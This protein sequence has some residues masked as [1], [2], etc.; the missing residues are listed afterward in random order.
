MS[1]GIEAKP[2]LLFFEDDYS[3]V[4]PHFWQGHVEYVRKVLRTHF[5]LQ[6]ADTDREY[7]RA[8]DEAEPDLI[9]FDGGVLHF[10]GRK[11]RELTN[12]GSDNSVPLVG[13]LRTDA[14]SPETIEAID[15]LEGYGVEAFFSIDTGMGVCVGDLGGRLFY[16]P[17]S[18]DETLFRDYGM[19]KL[20]P[21]SMT[22]YGFITDGTYPW[23]QCVFN[24]IAEN[25]PCFVSNRPNRKS[26]ILLHG[27]SYARVLNQSYVSLGCGC[28]RRIL[29]RK[30][31]EIPAC[32][33]LLG[34]EET[35]TAKAAGFVDGENCLFLDAMTA[36]D[37]LE[38]TFSDLERLYGM[39][40]SGREMV[41]RH[42]SMAAR[43]QLRD[44]LSLRKSGLRMSQTDPFAR[45]EPLKGDNQS[46]A[47]VH[48]GRDSMLNALRETLAAAFDA[49]SDEEIRA[50][51]A[52]YEV[53]YSRS[54][55]SDLIRSILDLD[56]GSEARAIYRLA[57]VVAEDLF[58]R[59]IRSPIE[60]G[61]IL[62]AMMRLGKTGQIA[63]MLGS[64]MKRVDHAFLESVLQ[65][66]AD[67]ARLLGETIPEIESGL[68]EWDARRC[69][70][71]DLAWEHARERFLQELGKADT[72]IGYA[73]SVI[74]E[75]G[76]A[77][78]GGGEFAKRFY[79]G[80]EDKGRF[81][82]M[83]DN[84]E[85]TA[86]GVGS[87]PVLNPEVVLSRSFSRIVVTNGLFRE[88]ALQLSALGVSWESIRILDRES[89][90][91]FCL[92]ETHPL[93]LVDPQ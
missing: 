47:V 62:V 51:L 85:T 48:F 68:G 41:L 15:L 30:M 88:S 66:L 75:D 83:L 25:F 69:R 22:G 49:R 64:G 1:E 80:S 16:W 23:R 70:V 38:E 21:V 50:A 74:E 89:M 56:A 31:L 29:V 13:L 43:S 67:Q 61:L 4:L 73:E 45:L 65:A 36:V 79:D 55:E 54:R 27:E 34:T 35:D 63:S 24:P 72:T 58:N 93:Q 2:R 59:E 14:D 37:K 86:H 17:W 60:F 26:P 84:N 44:W 42:H 28:H 19:E 6:I 7:E 32:M 92:S 53:Y 78:F 20:Y 82:C 71:A 11:A 46:A 87:L 77:I 8:V 76:W 18:L 5:N 91:L 40:R 52:E 10:N 33:A 57:P 3:Q 12:L 9:L 90:S 39:A 81:V